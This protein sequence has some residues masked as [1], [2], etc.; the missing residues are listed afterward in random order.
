MMQYAQTAVKLEE[1][2][3]PGL[4]GM[5]AGAR[6]KSRDKTALE[7]LIEVG[8]QVQEL[9]KKEMEDQ[10]KET[11]LEYQKMYSMVSKKLEKELLNDIQF[12]EKDLVDLAVTNLNGLEDKAADI[13]FGIYTGCLLNLLTLRNMAEGKETVVHFDGKGGIYTHLFA[14]AKHVDTLILE[15]VDGEDNACYVGAYGGRAKKVVIKNCSG[16]RIGSDIGSCKGRVDYFVAVDNSCRASFMDTAAYKGRAGLV[17]LVNNDSER[18]GSRTAKGRGRADV[19]VAVDN[20]DDMVLYSTANYDGYVGFVVAV[21][22]HHDDTLHNSTDEGGIIR[23]A[24]IENLNNEKIDCPLPYECGTIGELITEKFEEKDDY[25]GKFFLWW[26][27]GKIIEKDRSPKKYK[28]T[29]DKF[30]LDDMAQ[31]AKSISGKSGEEILETAEEI[32]SI[33]KSVKPLSQSVKETIRSVYTPGIFLLKDIYD[34][35]DNIN[36]DLFN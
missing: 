13:L 26:N 35:L 29:I 27:I 28:K 31:L 2:R 7:Y 23:L 1:L 5:L 21:D 22:N 36:L 17:L 3:L 10:I 15:N 32:Y 20:K 8:N 33:Y 24:R 14:Y 18:V 9:Y 11:Y 25:K 4:D 16:G 30:R 12:N 6:V 19:V 34:W